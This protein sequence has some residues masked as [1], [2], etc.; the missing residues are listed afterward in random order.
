MKAC[1]QDYISSVLYLYTEVFN[2][3]YKCSLD[4]DHKR[5]IA[6]MFWL[7]VLSMASK[8][9]VGQSK[10][11]E[12]NRVYHD[13]MN[14][15][16]ILFQRGYD[17]CDTAQVRKLLADDFE[18]YHDQAGI[19]ESGADFLH[20]LSSL[21]HL[22]YKASR[23]LDYNSVKLHLLRKQGELY[24]VL[25]SGSHSFYAES[26]QSPKHKTSTAAFHHLW[27]KTNGDWKLK[28]VISYDHQQP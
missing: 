25:Q 1:N 14:N 24:G 17:H 26:A 5:G 20:A 28:R 23:S 21:C 18:F 15:D 9:M 22:D 4:M 7:I 11:D 8:P 13:I 10:D 16:S 6:L 12:Y 27:I 19:I 2:K 3:A